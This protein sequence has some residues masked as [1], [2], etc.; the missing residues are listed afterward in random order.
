[1]AFWNAGST[2]I[3]IDADSAVARRRLRGLRE[4]LS[5]LLSS[6]DSRWYAFGFD[7]PSDPETPEV[8]EHPTVSAGAAGSCFCDWDDARRAES[9]RAK[10]LAGTTEVAERLVSESETHFTGLPR[11]VPLTLVVSALNDAGE[12]QP[13]QPVAFTL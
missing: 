3:P 5:Q 1:M 10:V 9:Y 12:S 8:P 13:A 4:E 2:G 6:Q 11:G 7:R